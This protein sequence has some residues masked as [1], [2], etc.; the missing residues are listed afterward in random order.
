[1]SWWEAA[2]LGSVQGVTEF[3]PVSSSAHL[4]L[5]QAALGVRLPGVLYEAA[6]H[7]ATLVAVVWV[8]RAR[9]VDLARGVVRGR[10]DAWLYV[11]LLALASV[12]AAVVGLWLRGPIEAAFEEPTLAAGLLLVTGALVATI[13]W[14]AEGAAEERPGGG[15]ALWVGFAQAAAILPGISRSG[16]T[17][18]A[19]VWRGVEPER[20]AEFSFLL[21]VPA[22]GGAALLELGPGQL[23]A[24]RELGPEL[25]VGFAAAAVTGVLAIRLFVRALR[26]GSFH[27]FAYY[28]WTVGGGYLLA[29][30]LWPPLRG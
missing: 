10:R 23:D 21:S 13:R 1:M 16:A 9:V 30:W 3:L 11:G 5:G 26:A 24:V 19:G 27:L 28:C 12:P 4:V 6:V 8:Y 29:A 2:L 25:A 7:L 20:M 18:A 15:G 17:V 14:T 22:V